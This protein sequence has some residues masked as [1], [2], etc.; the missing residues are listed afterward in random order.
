MS[1]KGK[2]IEFVDLKRQYASIS[3]EIDAAINEVIQNT[4]FRKR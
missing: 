2:T 3:K 4:R 1:N